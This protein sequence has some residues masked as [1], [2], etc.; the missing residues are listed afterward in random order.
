M[1]NT[2]PLGGKPIH[3]L[4]L[5]VLF[6]LA[7]SLV[8]VVFSHFTPMLATGPDIAGR[9]GLIIFFSFLTWLAHRNVRLAKYISVSSACLI[10]SCALFLDLYLSRWSLWIFGLDMHTPVGIAVDKLE[11]TL[12]VAMTILLLTRLLG[13]DMASLYLKKGNLLLGLAI[14]VLTFAFFT[15][16]AIPTAEKA[17]LGR[18]LSMARVIPLIPWVLIFVLANGF[19]EELLFRGLYFQKI[20]PFFGRFLTNVLVTLVFAVSHAGVRYT[21]DVVGFLVVLLP[22]S[23]ALG[24]TMQKTDS[25]WG[26]VLFHAGLDVPVVIGLYSNLA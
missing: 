19:N 5:F 14:G 25:I 16:T 15:A 6:L 3:Q 8:F 2:T 23:L 1:N 17:F 9:T 18:D 12:M 20:E 13:G 4:G 11:S 26:S 21:P 10:A 24:Y 22:L 7:G